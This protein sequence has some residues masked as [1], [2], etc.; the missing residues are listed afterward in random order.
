MEHESLS[1]KRMR[2]VLRGER[3]R[4]AQSLTPEQLKFVHG[5]LAPAMMDTLAHATTLCQGKLH[6]RNILRRCMNGYKQNAQ[7][8]RTMKEITRETAEQ[9]IN[10]ADGMTSD[11][12]LDAAWAMFSG[13]GW[14]R[15]LCRVSACLLYTSPSPRD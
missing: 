12:A 5:I 14:Q 15:T 6:F 4:R 13:S 9:W 3:R 2:A 10:V 7:H 11:A 8:L 1:R